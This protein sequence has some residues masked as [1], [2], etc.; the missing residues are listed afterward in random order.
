MFFKQNLIRF[1]AQLF[2]RSEYLINWSLGSVL[3]KAVSEAGVKILCIFLAYGAMYLS[4][5]IFSLV[6]LKKQIFM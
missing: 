6:D 1:A 2:D 4:K 5:D 3:K